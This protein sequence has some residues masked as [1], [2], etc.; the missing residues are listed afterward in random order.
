MLPARRRFCFAPGLIPRQPQMLP[1]AARR[2][3]FAQLRTTPPPPIRP[4][5]RPRL[6][7]GQRPTTVPLRTRQRVRRR[8]L[9]EPRRIHAQ[10]QT[11]PYAPGPTRAQGPTPQRPQM[12][13]AVR[14]RHLLE[15]LRTVQ[16]LRMLRAQGTSSPAPDR[17]PPLRPILRRVPSR[18]SFEPVRTQLRLRT[19]PCGCRSTP[20]PLLI[21]SRRRT[22]LHATPRCWR[23]QLPTRLQPATRLAEH[24]KPPPGQPPTRLPGLIPL[25][26]ARHEPVRAPTPRRQ[27]TWCPARP[28]R[29]FG[30]RRILLQL[31]TWRVRGTRY[32]VRPRIVPQPRMWSLAPLRRSPAPARTPP[33]PAT[34]LSAWEQSPGLQPIRRPLRMLLA[35][36]RR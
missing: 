6:S 10:R 12:G 31:R 26:A 24:R 2:R 17:T 33:A 8:S 32:L 30:L 25:V 35:A 34:P 15:R 19:A 27:P 21:L 4:A 1:L 3:W 22:R 11:A 23:E 20:A 28:R 9:P 36:Q 29:L 14:P 5:G 13:P 18:R 7:P 16:L